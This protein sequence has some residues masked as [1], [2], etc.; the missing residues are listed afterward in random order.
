MA[1]ELSATAGALAFRG[2]HVVTL[3]RL[4]LARAPDRPTILSASFLRRRRNSDREFLL[5]LENRKRSRHFEFDAASSNPG[6]ERGF[7]HEVDQRRAAFPMVARRDDSLHHRGRLW[8]PASVVPI[9]ARADCGRVR[10]RRLCISG[11]KNFKPT[12]KSCLVD[13][14]RDFVRQS[15]VSLH[16][17]ILS[18]AFFRRV[19]GCRIEIERNDA[20]KFVNRRG[21]HW[22]SDDFLL[23]R[24][25]GLAL[26]GKRRGLQWQSQ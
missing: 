9:A 8:Q 16:A 6:V 17:A 3:S 20:E 22:R 14:P 2:D 1:L 11:V 25:Q 7:Y 26:P 18:L 5:V 13:L 24:A 23:R 10:G 4:V 21:G 19:A 12:D 15:R